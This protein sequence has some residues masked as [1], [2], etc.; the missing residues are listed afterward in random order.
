MNISRWI[1]FIS[2]FSAM[3]IF[4]QFRSSAGIEIPG[5]TGRLKTEGMIRRFL[6]EILEND[7]SRVF[8]IY[9]SVS[10]SL[11]MLSIIF[12]IYDELKGFHIIAFEYVG[13]FILARNKLEYLVNP[14]S[15][16]DLIAIMPWD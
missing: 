2:I 4:Y 15:V 13:R 3:E 14:L 16:A 5:P 10:F 1:L 6:H 11:L 12:G 7:R 8:V 9:Q